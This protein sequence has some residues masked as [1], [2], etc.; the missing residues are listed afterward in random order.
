MAARERQPA[1]AAEIEAK[2]PV[3]YAAEVV[4][5]F[6]LVF[7]ICGAVSASTQGGLALDVVGL[8]FVHA[9]ALAVGIYT[10]GGTSGG[11]FNPGVTAGLFAVGEIRGR[12]A[13]IYVVCQCVG[14]VLAA[15]VVLL[16]FHDAGD[17]VN[18]AAPAINPDV[19]TD[20]SPLLA[21]VA[22]ALGTAILVW[23]VMGMAVNPRA[24]TPFAPLVIGLSLG[25]A[26][27]I[28]ANA[29]SASLNPARWLG[30]S[31]VSGH[32]DD[33]WVYILGPVIGGVA[34]AVGYRALVLNPRG[35]PGTR[36]VDVLEENGPDVSRRA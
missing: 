7:A 8:G 32:F 21:L 15:L 28:F 20:G 18:Y 2:T 11:H 35:L 4:G 31:L 9:I 33:F 36:P 3:A 19:I 34:A 27:M 29:T 25:V 14:A 10:L 17:P 13:G 12:D 1:R 6:L 24:E 22:E 26:V 23:A 30:P 16:L 5:T